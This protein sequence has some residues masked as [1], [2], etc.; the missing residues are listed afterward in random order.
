VRR[1]SAD[2]LE[3]TREGLWESTAALADLSLPDRERVVDV[4]CGSGEF[5]RVLAAESPASVVGVDADPALLAVARETVD[6]AFVAG[7]A[8]R[9]PLRDEAADLVGCQALLVNLPDPARAVAEFAR[10]SADLVAAVEPDNAAVA[11]ESTVDAESSLA[12]T[13]RAAYLDGV[14]TDV[15]LGERVPALFRAAGLDDVRTRRHYHQK[16]IEPPYDAADVESVQRKATGAALDGHEREL[17][18]ALS[19]R[20]YEELRR[21]WRSMGREAAAQMRD[22][23]Y[24]RVEVVPFDVTVGRV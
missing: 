8:T 9:L 2:Y 4:G 22:G 13:L 16:R 24:V 20:R 19:D 11:V 6:A 12:A 21:D 3:R 7:D 14:E 5:T 18:R 10:V 15:A 1:F 23:D 17:R